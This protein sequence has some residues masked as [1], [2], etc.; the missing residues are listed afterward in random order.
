MEAALK[1]SLKNFNS[2]MIEKEFDVLTKKESL[3]TF[4]SRWRVRK[5]I[6]MLP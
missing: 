3:F 5:N 4:L 6:F 2:E 1:N